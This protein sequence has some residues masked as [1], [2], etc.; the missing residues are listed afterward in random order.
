MHS[1]FHRTRNDMPVTARRGGP[2]ALPGAW[3]S[4][5]SRSMEAAAAGLPPPTWAARGGTC[6]WATDTTPRDVPLPHRPDQLVRLPDDEGRVRAVNDGFYD[7]LIMSYDVVIEAVSLFQLHRRRRR[8][9]VRMGEV[10]RAEL[11][12]VHHERRRH[13]LVRLPDEPRRVQ[14]ILPGRGDGT[15]WWSTVDPGRSTSRPPRRGSRSRLTMGRLTSHGRPS[16]MR[17]S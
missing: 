4:A 2:R 7:G 13:R 1:A 17:R 10:H 14:H 16:R 11:Q 8:G 9:P 3:I 15:A 12:R 6:S 5:S